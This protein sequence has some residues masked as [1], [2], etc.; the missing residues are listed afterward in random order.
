MH[1]RLSPTSF[2]VIA[3]LTLAGTAPAAAQLF[4]FPR[5]EPDNELVVRLNRAEDQ[6]RQL[7]G[8]VEELEH[9]N[10]VLLQQVEALRGGAG[11]ASQSGQIQRSPA[12]QSGVAPGAPQ[13]QDASGAPV[14][15]AARGDAFD[16]AA[17][18]NA[19]GAPR[20]LGSAPPD[21]GA[22][23]GSVAGQPLDLARARPGA[24]PADAGTAPITNAAAGPSPTLPPTQRPKDQFD[25]G[26]GYILH[27]D[28]AL[29]EDALADFVKKYP[30]DR[31]TAE[32]QFWLGEAR[33]QRHR[34]RDA[35]EAFL[36]ISTK[37]DTAAKA[38]DALLRLGQSLAALGERE[39]ACAAFGEVGRKYPHA[40]A[41]V[42]KGVE[43]EQKRGHC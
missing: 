16:P 37:F 33:F 34:Y 27:K 9:Q 25:L 14:R 18:P 5:S 7:T 30:S 19:P 6:V 43:F 23:G 12:M 32:A 41:N 22:P 24:M 1:A 28:Y 4:S 38:P 40:P 8:K 20:A 21:V 26:Y 17:N 31:L 3:M 11:V 15:G 42:K 13:A 36:A 2:A 39:A 29:A 10:R 35:A